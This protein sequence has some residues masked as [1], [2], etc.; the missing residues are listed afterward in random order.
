MVEQAPIGAWST[1]TNT[2]WF[3]ESRVKAGTENLPIDNERRT[4]SRSLVENSVEIR[5]ANFW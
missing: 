5:L 4:G 3:D 1:F 2:N